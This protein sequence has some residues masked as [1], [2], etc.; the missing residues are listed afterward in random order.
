VSALDLGMHP[1]VRFGPEGWSLHAR[2]IIV[3]GDISIPPSTM[4]RVIAIDVYVICPVGGQPRVTVA[5]EHVSRE[6][7]GFIAATIQECV[8]LFNAPC[9]CGEPYAMHDAASPHG[10]GACRS[11]TA[12]DFS[13]GVEP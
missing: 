4:P 11:F 12:A 6:R 3:D 5:A 13:K 10:C 7:L 2:R 8:A 1:H 9:M